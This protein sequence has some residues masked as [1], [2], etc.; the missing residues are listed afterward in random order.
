MAGPRFL[1]VERMMKSFE[2]LRSRR[3]RRSGGDRLC[4]LGCPCRFCWMA[5]WRWAPKACRAAS[6]AGA[7]SGGSQ[8]LGMCSF[9][10]KSASKVSS[11]FQNDF[12]RTSLIRRSMVLERLGFGSGDSMQNFRPCHSSLSVCGGGCFRVQR[13]WKA[14]WELFCSEKNCGRGIFASTVAVRSQRGSLGLHQKPWSSRDWVLLRW[15]CVM[16]MGCLEIGARGGGVSCLCFRR[17][18]RVPE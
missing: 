3:R 12:S 14:V 5:W 8:L 16:T 6:T 11:S 17:L 13:L 4:W 15:H 1:S 9:G 7:A 10:L 18:K 2:C